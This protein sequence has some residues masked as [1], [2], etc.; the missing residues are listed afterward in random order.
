[1]IICFVAA[2]E[3]Q[4]AATGGNTL[5]VAQ[6][7]KAKKKKKTRMFGQTNKPLF[8]TAT[9][10]NGCGFGGFGTSTSTGTLSLSGAQNKVGLLVHIYISAFGRIVCLISPAQP[11]MIS[12]VGGVDFI[13]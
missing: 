8:G 6:L 12:R 2:F 5:F 11:A 9:T 13:P 10:S 7:Q 3:P 4:P 1:M